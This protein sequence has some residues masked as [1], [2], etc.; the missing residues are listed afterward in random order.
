M[1]KLLFA[2]DNDPVDENAVDF[3]CHLARLTQSRLTGIFLNEPVDEPEVVIESHTTGGGMTSI[4]IAEFDKESEQAA[5]HEENIAVFRDWA[6]KS[7]ISF[8][9][10]LDKGVPVAELGYETRY[11]D[12][13]LMSADT[14]SKVDEPI[15]SAFVKQMI[16][17]SA[18]PVILTPESFER[19]DNIVFCYDG[20]KSSLFAI[21]QFA[22]LF[23]QL[24]SQRVK[25]ISLAA[26]PPQPQEQA[27]LTQ[28]LG[29]HY[30][31]VEWIAQGAEAAEALFHYLL[32][33]RD[34]FVIMGPYGHGLL[35]GFFEPDYETGTIRTTS[36]PIFIA[37][38]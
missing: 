16:H 2:V 17:D 11:A 23:P 1:E 35:T 36:L 27:R 25:V 22:Y 10:F 38:C 3:A 19:I 31:D 5:Q 32:K 15:P 28:W 14:F 26:E 30:S 7:G 34:D 6:G 12:L 8:S 18:C 13:L 9:I 37:H 4:T 20:S 33:K 29:Y 21:K 24:R